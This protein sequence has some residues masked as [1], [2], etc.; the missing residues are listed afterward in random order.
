MFP[1]HVDMFGLVWKAVPSSRF[2][3]YHFDKYQQYQ[4]IYRALSV[5]YPVIFVLFSAP[6]EKCEMS[7]HFRVIFDP[8]FW[9]G[10]LNTSL[11]W[12]GKSRSMDM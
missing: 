9:N 8:T 11:I 5:E 4:Y 6:A 7:F 3:C 1:Q 10:P 12:R 2:E